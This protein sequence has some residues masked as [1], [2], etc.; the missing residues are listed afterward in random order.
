MEAAGLHVRPYQVPVP[1]FGVWGFALARRDPF[2]PPIEAP[3]GLRFLD[4]DALKGMFA[5]PAD[6][7]PEQVEINRLDNQVLVRYYD[8]EWRKWN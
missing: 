6:L 2:E 7:G 4:T 8:A 1:A 5:L 3:P